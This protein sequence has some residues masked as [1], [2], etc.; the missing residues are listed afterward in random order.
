M[1]LWSLLVSHSFSRACANLECA[2]CELAHFTVEV[3]VRAD[4]MR[5]DK[6][7]RLM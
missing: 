5:L 6:L 3:E 4:M 7:H 2:Y 1:I